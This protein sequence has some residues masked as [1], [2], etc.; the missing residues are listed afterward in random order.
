MSDPWSKE[1]ND[2]VV[3]RLE[4]DRYNALYEASCYKSKAE[5]LTEAFD[6]ADGLRR[7]HQAEIVR[8]NADNEMLRDELEQQ[9]AK[10]EALEDIIRRALAVPPSWGSEVYDIEDILKEAATEQE[11]E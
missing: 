3:E 11:G 10:V 2:K 1:T 5:R 8:L 6:L 4:Q 7:S 9:Y